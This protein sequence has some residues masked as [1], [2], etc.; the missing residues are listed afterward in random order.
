M[1]KNILKQIDKII[2]EPPKVCIILGSGLN[3]FNKSLKNI[4]ILRYNQI[5]GFFQTSVKGHKGEFIYGFLNDIPILCASGRFHYYEKYSFEDIG[6]LIKIFKYYKPTYYIITNSSGCL[7]LDWDIGS[8]MLI[9]EFIDFSFIESNKFKKYRVKNNLPNQLNIYEG[10]YAYTIGPTY[11]TQSEIQEIIKLGGH[12][13]GM[14]TFPEYLM[15][16]KLN[17]KPIIISCLTNYG[18]GLINKKI[19]HKDV[20]F[21][22]DKVKN[23][24]I[25]LLIKIIENIEPQKILKK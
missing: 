12:A 3:N 21:N 17:I 22:A 16:K 11:E 24:F 14:S 25:S 15:C 19:S 23:E 2:I 4:K 1:N 10:T 7:R 18:A 9:K 6:I 8:F 20:L 13:V 5:N